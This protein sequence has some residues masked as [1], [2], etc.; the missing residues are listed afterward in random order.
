MDL[1]FLDEWTVLVNCIWEYLKDSKDVIIA[2]LAV[3]FTIYIPFLLYFYQEI[4]WKD[5]FKY[6]DLYIFHNDVFV[7]KKVFW[8]II[9]LVF[10]LLFWN[11][12]S[13]SSYF[14]INIEIILL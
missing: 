3:I 6:L 2:L 8:S 7:L 13:D 1:L 5:K 14:W 11:S 12:S 10:I 9:F 4:N